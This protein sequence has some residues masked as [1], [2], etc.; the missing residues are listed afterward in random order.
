RAAG[1]AFALPA[2]AVGRSNYEAWRDAGAAM[3][4][5][6]PAAVNVLRPLPPRSGALIFGLPG[7][8]RGA[9]CFIGALRPAF[10]RALNRRD[11]WT[12]DRNL[13]VFDVVMEFDSELHGPID[14]LAAPP[15]R[16][17][18][19]VAT[20]LRFRAGPSGEVDDRLACRFLDG[21]SS[22][23]DRGEWARRASHS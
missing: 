13:G 8:L 5:V 21:G 22:N 6:V 17:E 3:E 18:P 1:T 2:S 7:P 23:G 11:F 4:R 16:L 10:Q 15:R 19:G 20:T 12:A 9:H 14:P